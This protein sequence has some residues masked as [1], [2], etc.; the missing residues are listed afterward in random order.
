[1]R[2]DA[3]DIMGPIMIGPSSSHT[4]GAVR[5]GLMAG[6]L[7]NYNPTEIEVLFHGS[8]ASTY[9]FHKTDVAVIA[10]VLGMPVDDE[11]IKNS[12]SIAKERNIH[13]GFGT[14]NIDGA[15]PSTIV[16]KLKCK[17]KEYL[18]RSAT[19]GGGN[20]L[21]E[22]V[23][24]NK[25]DMNGKQYNLIVDVSTEDLNELKKI[26][27]EEVSGNF[28]SGCNKSNNR[29]FLNVICE[30]K[31]DERKIEKI[32]NLNGVNDVYY[33]S[34]IMSAS[35]DSLS[36]FKTVK[37]L[38]DKSKE[39]DC[40]ISDTVI[41]F[42]CTNSNRTEKE[43]IAEMEKNLTSMKEAIN[44][45]SENENLMLGNIF[46]GNARKMSTFISDK[47]SICGVSLSKVIKNALAVME[48]NGSMGKVVA[49]PT[50]GSAGTLPAAVITIAEIN[51]I[52]D[53]KVVKSLFTG[54][55]LGMIIAENSTISGSVGGCQAECGVAS[56]MAAAII[57]ELFGG[58][59][60]QILSSSS[61]ALG[62]ILGLVCDPVAGT[63]ELPCIQRNVMA[64]ANAI[65]SAEMALAGVDSVIPLDEIIGALDEVG[66][67]MDK[68]LK[69]TLG[70]GIS[71]TPTARRLEA[72]L[73]KK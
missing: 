37:E 44:N 22:E 23:N 38:V 1:M 16:I 50:A 49:C 48:V 58:T 69:D 35:N 11:R 8:L 45:G 19:I 12:V 13:V 5:I 30:D 46:S 3:F 26:I 29:Y 67:L 65:V 21:I 52:E 33:F 28:L 4:A 10:G 7:C 62:N 40:L 47:R 14:I 68:S 60:E 64:A 53:E 15:H 41:K 17:D 57:T 71:N 34:P 56:A 31:I 73:F 36:F 61:L 9:S 25:A 20:I 66:K 6:Q 59:Y 2:F 54:A 39:D 63:V 24:G 18:I 51:N 32:K 70:A 42:E 55:G 43:V 72:D 27:S